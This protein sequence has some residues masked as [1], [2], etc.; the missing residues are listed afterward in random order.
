[1]KLDLDKQV[2]DLVKQSG[3]S[4]YRLAIDSGLSN[5][6]ICRFLSKD[7][8]LTLRSAGKILAALSIRVEFKQGE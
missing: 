1:M 7:Q 6:A 4:Q 8:T 3:V 2:R 5:A